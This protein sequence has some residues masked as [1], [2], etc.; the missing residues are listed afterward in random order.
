MRRVLGGSHIAAPSGLVLTDPGGDLRRFCEG[1]YAYY[2][3]IGSTDPDRIEPLDVLVTV[4]VNSFVNSAVKVHRVHR[5]LVEACEPPLAGIPEQADLLTCDPDLA[6]TEQLLD[7]ACRVPGVLLPVAT[8]VLHRKRR[9]LIPML[10]NVLLNHYLAS[11]ERSVLK[12]ATQDG[13]RAASVARVVL[14]LFRADLAA[15]VE[16][17]RP[18][19]EGLASLGYPLTPLRMLEIL[20]WIETEPG[21]TYRRLRKA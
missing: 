2:D 9:R 20:V 18:I 12:T 21:G 10:D 16:A 4:A 19:G 11:P 8:K 15:S 6:L 14:K 13:R 1:E 3:G 7:A 5:G 17:L